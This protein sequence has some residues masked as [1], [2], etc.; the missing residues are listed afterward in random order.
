MAIDDTIPV[1][2]AGA[3]V[4]SEGEGLQRR[5]GGWV[6]AGDYLEALSLF[7]EWVSEGAG[8]AED[9]IRGDPLRE[10]DAP[11]LGHISTTGAVV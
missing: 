9:A 8:D 10:E 7:R 3:G 6:P 2:P 11:L 5:W 1:V 4:G